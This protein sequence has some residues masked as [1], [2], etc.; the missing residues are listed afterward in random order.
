M[1]SLWKL[2]QNNNIFLY[3]VFPF[4]VAFCCRS[5]KAQHP[6]I[7]RLFSMLITL[8]W[9]PFCWELSVLLAQSHLRCWGWSPRLEQPPPHPSHVLR[10][11]LEGRAAALALQRAAKGTT[12]DPEMELFGC[13]RFC[14]AWG[15]EAG[16][17]CQCGDRCGP[18]GWHSHLWHRGEAE[19]DTEFSFMEMHSGLHTLGVLGDVS[20]QLPNIIL[21][22][23]WCTE[24]PT[25][26]SD[27]L[28]AA[29]W[30]CV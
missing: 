15:S 4:Q 17:L 20:S 1:V 16:K 19:S 27:F 10:V 2:L 3:T 28:W 5:T 22:L 12:G 13:K 9:C 7:L 21:V 18:C 6:H 8:C 14:R 29:G 30:G 24:Q 25:V 23:K 11:V 26:I